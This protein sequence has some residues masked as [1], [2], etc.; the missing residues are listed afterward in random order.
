M[1]AEK[2][3]IHP[4]VP[5]AAPGPRRRLLSEI[6]VADVSDLYASIPEV[7]KLKRPLDLPQALPGEADLRR[8]VEGLLAKNR[9]TRELLNFRGAGCWQHYVP[10]ICDEI[11]GRGEF[12][13]AY[14]GGTYSDHGKNQALF[15]FQSMMGELVGMEVVSA[16]TYDYGAAANSAVLMACRLTGRDG[17]LV[18]EL[19]SAERLSQ[20]RGF[21]KP[22]AKIAALKQEPAT[23]LI[24]LADLEAKLTDDIAAVYFDVPGYLGMIEHR[25]AEIAERAHAEGAMVVVGVDPISLGVLAP[26][27]DYGADFVVGDLQPLGIHMYAGGGCGGF[28]A[29][30]DEERFVA[31]YPMIMLSAAPAQGDGELG[32]GWSTMERTSYDKRHES[33]DYY[34]TTQ[35][36]WGIGAGVYLALMGPKGLRE[37]GE[38][39]MQR[40]CYAAQ[41]IAGIKSV[42]LPFMETPFFKE[43][44][45]SFDGTGKT[46]AD[47]NTALRERDILGGVDLSREHPALGQSALYCVTEVHGK[48]D[49]DRLVAGL[50]EACR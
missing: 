37:L 25:G 47:I 9:S 18:P 19:M 15:E 48:E 46:V 50:E 6:G 3:F 12:L 35:W 44:V 14:A 28:V 34:G 10:A 33:T 36:V 31:E 32:Y 45:V 38:G 4:Y 39:I 26:P 24:D 43:F 13:T 1:A 23:G 29:S 20:M 21:T 22:V 11:T 5:N 30:R 2:G 8:H 41:R 27:A 49:I 7:L 17:V 16:P 42:T 40:A